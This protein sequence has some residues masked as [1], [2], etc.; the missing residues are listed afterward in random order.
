MARI[1]T[2]IAVEIG[3]AIR[4]AAVALQR[5]LA[6]AGASAKWV[7]PQNIHVS[8]LFLGD[9]EELDLVPICRAVKEVAAREPAFPLSVS[10]VGAFPNARRPKVL[11]AGITDGAE[12]L[13]RLYTRL[14]EKL[15][16]LGCYRKE[17]RAYTPHVTLGRVKADADANALAAELAKLRTWEGGHTTVDEVLVFSSELRPDGPEY[18]VIGRGEL[19]DG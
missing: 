12:Q 17:E 14:E 2:F 1:R 15:L 13:Q 18:T 4:D 7:E 11:W 3:D 10:G 6:R 9:V 16:D 5:Q 19:A 8:L